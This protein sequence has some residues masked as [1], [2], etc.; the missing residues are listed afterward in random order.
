MTCS[1]CSAAVEGALAGAPGV[2]HTA[3][4]LTLQEA[5]VEYDAEE[6]DEVIQA[7]CVQEVV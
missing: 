7:G 1:S 5:K 2:R 3:V 6:T 4:S